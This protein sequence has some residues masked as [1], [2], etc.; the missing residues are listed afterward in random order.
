MLQIVITESKTSPRHLNFLKQ[1][2]KTTEMMH[3]LEVLDLDT[4]T[5]AWQGQPTRAG[6]GVIFNVMG[7]L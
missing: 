2:R 6:V 5:A 4:C 3:L 7:Y 1:L